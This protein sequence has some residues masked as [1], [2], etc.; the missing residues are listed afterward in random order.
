MPV[1]RKHPEELLAPA[2]L[3]ASVVRAFAPEHYH[4][5]SGHPLPHRVPWGRCTPTDCLD[6]QNMADRVSLYRTERGFGEAAYQKEQGPWD[7]QQDLLPMGMEQEAVR[8]KP[9]GIVEAVVQEARAAEAIV[10]SRAY[11]ERGAR[12]A[13][14]PLPEEPAPPPLTEDHRG[15]VE[16]RLEQLAPLAVEELAFELKFGSTEARR[17]AARDVLDR[18][19]FG[20]NRQVDGGRNGPV[21]IVNIGGGTP[22]DV[23]VQKGQVVDGRAGQAA[24]G[25]PP[26]RKP[27]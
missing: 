12:Q 17:E 19:G 6:D 2:A 9:E 10:L 21:L 25:L 13:L 4:C 15:Y 24:A 14:H 20:K 23:Q 18:V 3:S 16:K 8:E 5:P 26:G 11:A 7:R 22:Y 1:P 27:K